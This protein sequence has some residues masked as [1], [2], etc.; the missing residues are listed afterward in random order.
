MDPFSIVF[1][2]L[3]LLAGAVKA[4]V[5]VRKRCRVIQHFPRELQRLQGKLDRQHLIFVNESHLLIRVALTDDVAIEQ[6]LEDPQHSQ[7]QSSE[8]EAA[9]RRFLANSYGVYLR[10]VEEVCSTVEGLEDEFSKYDVP[11]MTS[12]EDSYSSPTA[13]RIS[14]RVTMACNMSGFEKMIEGLRELNGDLGRLR[15]QACE[16]QQPGFKPP[17][18]LK[19]ARMCSGRRDYQTVRRASRGLHQAL[20]DGWSENISFPASNTRHDVKL[21]ANA[22]VK[23]D[24][25]L[26]LAI[27]CHGHAFSRQNTVTEP[28]WSILH[29]RSEALEWMDTGWDTPPASDD[30]IAPKRRRVHSANDSSTARNA[31]AHIYRGHT[32]T[33]DD[34]DE[35]RLELEDPALPYATCLGLQRTGLKPSPTQSPCCLGYADNSSEDGFRHSFYQSHQAGYDSKSTIREKA[36]EMPYTM[37]DILAEALDGCQSILRQLM[38]ARYVV[39][40]VL[41]FYSTPWLSEYVTANDILFLGKL[42]KSD[43]ARH[44][45]TIHLETSFVQ[46]PRQRFPDTME[47]LGST[48][49]FEDAKIQYGVRNI[50]LWCLGTMLLQIASWR[51]IDAADD[52]STIRR[53]SNLSYCPGPRYQRLTKKCLECDFGCGDDL[54]QPRLQQA[55]Y[56]GLICELNDMIQSLDMN[57]ES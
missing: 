3:P 13:P 8:L 48:K 29:V 24:V 17:D 39:A 31:A 10:I 55:V 9:L 49:A 43:L 20:V 45:D 44:L 28:A 11:T 53:L 26:D 14:S 42:E 52:V 12:P 34:F 47:A 46:A 37:S 51:V 57:V 27:L 35:E 2:V 40:T 19:K 21:F 50:T 15:Q 38:L 25:Q 56:K 33:P 16:L 30:D 36:V 6:M 22:R 1:A 23:E 41:K 7:W 4:Y 54:S 5:S 18:R 32:P